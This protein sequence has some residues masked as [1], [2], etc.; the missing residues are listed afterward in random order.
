MMKNKLTNRMAIGII[1]LFAVIALASC[2]QGVPV[3]DARQMQE[4]I[5]S[6]SNRVSSIESTLLGIKEDE[7][8]VGSAEVQMVFD[9][10]INELRDISVRMAE[11][12]AK[13]DFPEPE[14]AAPTMDGGMPGGAAPGF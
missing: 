3:E 5:K 7:V 4:E 8:D 2:S 9:D 1:V 6:I 14:D 13:L 10:L 12:E 11:I